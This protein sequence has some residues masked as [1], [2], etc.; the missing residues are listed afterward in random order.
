METNEKT[1][2]IINAIDEDN[3]NHVYTDERVH[4]RFPPEPNGYLHIGHAKASLLNYRIAKNTTESLTCVLTTPTLSRKTLNMSTRS[5]KIYPG[6]A[7]TGK[8]VST[9]RLAIFQKWRNTPLSSLKGPGL[10][11]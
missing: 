5:K 10:C 7:L 1:N 11:R 9:L 8:T 4:T 3:K 6:W 2:F